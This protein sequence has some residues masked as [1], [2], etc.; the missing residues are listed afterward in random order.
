MDGLVSR[1]DEI[2]SGVI[3]VKS[4]IPTYIKKRTILV[5]TSQ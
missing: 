3:E 4:S 1:V 5:I 2:R